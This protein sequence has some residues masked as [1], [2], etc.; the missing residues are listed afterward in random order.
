LQSNE[1]MDREM[2]GDCGESTQ[3]TKSMS[4]R[5]RGDDDQILKKLTVR[6]T[7]VS[8]IVR[9]LHSLSTDEIVKFS[10]GIAIPGHLMHLVDAYVGDHTN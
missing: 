8:P 1:K 3:S 10:Y 5:K 4:E 9:G 7:V 2:E 6:S